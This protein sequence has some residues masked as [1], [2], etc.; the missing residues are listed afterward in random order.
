MVHWSNG[1]RAAHV[2]IDR[3]RDVT[4]V[5]RK[6]SRRKSEI[7]ELEERSELDILARQK[8]KVNE[9]IRNW[10]HMLD[11]YYPQG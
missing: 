11:G 8:F 9:N 7:F 1:Q 3:V 2:Y 5:R 6:V 10:N 4:G